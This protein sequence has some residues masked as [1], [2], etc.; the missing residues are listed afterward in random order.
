MPWE[1]RGIVEQRMQFIADYQSGEWTMNELCECHGI[2]RKT[3]YKLVRRVEVEG[4]EGL[5]DQS[6]AP[7]RHPNQV[8]AAVQKQILELKQ[9][10]MSWGARKL[11]GWFVDH[12]PAQVWPAASTMGEI[13]KREGLVGCRQRRHRTPAY[14]QPFAEASQANDVWCV[15]FKGWFLTQDGERIDPFTMTDAY[16]RYLLRCQ[17][18]DK[19]DTPTVRAISEAAFREYGLPRAIRSDNGA[20][21][22]SRAVAGISRLSL[23]WMKLGIVAERIE[24]GHPEQNGRHERMH[25]TLAEET[26]NPAGKNRR[27][28]QWR[29][30]Q[31]RREYNE[32]R[33]HE[34]LGQKPPSAFYRASLRCY[35]SR[36]REPEYDSGWLVRS[37]WSHGQFDWKHNGIFLS[38]VLAGERIGLEQL[39]EDYWRIYFASFPI[40]YFDSA[41]LRICPLVPQ[42]KLSQE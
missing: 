6:R 22:A 27:E 29:F 31:F 8:S 3:G 24:R 35:P 28:Q 7:H 30:G 37:V 16:S 5:K 1:E 23:Y 42:Y 39:A 2:S 15:D 11:R 9:A 10:H 14:T 38:K 21:F 17:A 4:V 41:K 33:P 20:P 26:A 13:L 32:V 12:C 25:R 19:S 34:A 40:A 18:V 36:I